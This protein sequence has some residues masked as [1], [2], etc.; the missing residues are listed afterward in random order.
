VVLFAVV[1]LPVGVPLITPEVEFKDN[2]A[3]SDVVLKL[4]GVL[5]AVIV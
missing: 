2:P 1:K 5:L 4:V 3:G